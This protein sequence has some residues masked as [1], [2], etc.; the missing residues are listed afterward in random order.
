MVFSQKA[1]LLIFPGTEGL[2]SQLHSL[3]LNHSNNLCFLQAPRFGM[4]FP[5]KLPISLVLT[6]SQVHIRIILWV[7][8]SIAIEIVVGVTVQIKTTAITLITTYQALPII[9]G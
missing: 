3:D 6:V 4:N 8:R 7:N 2:K 9:E 5:L 1:W